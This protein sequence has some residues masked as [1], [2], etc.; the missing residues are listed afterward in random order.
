MSD[1][2]ITSYTRKNGFYR[3]L[4]TLFIEQRPRYFAISSFSSCLFVTKIS[5]GNLLGS[6][7]EKQTF[8]KLFIGRA[9]GLT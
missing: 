1:R 6:Y 4:V 2:K 8:N 3:D 9:K 5:Q 7:E